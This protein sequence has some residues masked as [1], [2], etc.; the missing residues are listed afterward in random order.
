MNLNPPVIPFLG[1][2]SR[3][4]QKI[5]NSKS[6]FKNHEA[7]D[8]RNVFFNRFCIETKLPLMQRFESKNL[9]VF[10]LATNF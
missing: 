1:P 4:L 3:K 8:V 6:R 9:F 10:F 7:L 5:F 2:V